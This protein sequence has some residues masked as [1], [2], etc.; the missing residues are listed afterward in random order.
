MPRAALRNTSKSL[1]KSA[2]AQTIRQARTWNGITLDQLGQATGISVPHLNRME[3]GYRPCS[4]ETEELIRQKIAEIIAD[5]QEGAGK[6]AG[7]TEQTP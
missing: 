7:P 1:T 6:T 3:R 4:P 5:R 2:P